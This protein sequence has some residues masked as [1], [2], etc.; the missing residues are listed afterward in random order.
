MVKD[1]KAKVLPDEEITCLALGAGGKR[2]LR[3]V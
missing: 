2:E 1:L 3:R